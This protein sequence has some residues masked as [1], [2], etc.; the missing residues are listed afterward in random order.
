MLPVLSR[1]VVEGK[2]RVAILDQAL[3]S[4]FDEE[5]K[6]VTTRRPVSAPSGTVWVLVS[7]LKSLCNPRATVLSA[8]RELLTEALSAS[9]WFSIGRGFTV[10]GR[11]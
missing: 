11:C 8:E 3:D 1:K 6:W 2:Q 10:F 9:V 4:L 7:Q 5:S